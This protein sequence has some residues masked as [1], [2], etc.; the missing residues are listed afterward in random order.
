MEIIPCI[1]VC[2]FKIL[3]SVENVCYSEGFRN[4]FNVPDSVEQFS[5]FGHL[6]GSSYCVLKAFFYIILF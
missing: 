1:R 2:I 4:I 6:V 5:N 3:F